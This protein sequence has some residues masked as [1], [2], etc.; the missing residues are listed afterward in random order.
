MSKRIFNGRYRLVEKLDDSMIVEYI[1]DCSNCNTEAGI[2]VT[3][4]SWAH[5]LIENG[6]FAEPL[7]CPNCHE[8]Y[9]VFFSSGSKIEY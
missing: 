2:L 6:G 9:D 5:E 8:E 3:V 7:K 1:F 4:D